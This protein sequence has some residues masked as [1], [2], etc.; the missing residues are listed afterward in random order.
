[1]HYVLLLHQFRQP[2]ITQ[3]CTK[4]HNLARIVSKIFRDDA[5]S[6]TQRSTAFCAPGTNTD[7]RVPSIEHK[8]APRLCGQFVVAFSIFHV[9]PKGP[10]D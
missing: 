6:Y 1:M 4:M 7:L 2:N 10:S 9:L 8:S 5:P 3:V